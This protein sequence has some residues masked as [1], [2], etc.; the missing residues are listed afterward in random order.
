[1]TLI[2]THSLTDQ[3]TPPPHL[4]ECFFGFLGNWH[5]V[6]RLNFVIQVNV[7]DGLTQNVAFTS[8]STLDNAFLLF[9]SL[10]LFIEMVWHP[11]SVHDSIKVKLNWAQPDGEKNKAILCI[12]VYDIKLNTPSSILVNYCL[13]GIKIVWHKV[14]TSLYHITKTSVLDCHNSVWM[15]HLTR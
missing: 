12:L 13:D 14:L 5:F 1:M 3:P 9:F 7:G 11:A 8:I 4:N 10:F 6:F 15:K 2:S